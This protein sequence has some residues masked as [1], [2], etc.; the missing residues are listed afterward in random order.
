MKS[1]TALLLILLLTGPLVAAEVPHWS[2]TCVAWKMRTE[3]EKNHFLIGYLTG[4]ETVDMTRGKDNKM[5]YY[6]WPRGF[7][8]GGV[9]IEL[10][11]LCAKP[12]NIDRRLGELVAVF[13]MTWESR[14][15]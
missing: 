9:V 8:V 6:F 10:D 2:E 11:V 14:L 7:R 3:T 5:L 15:K 1:I 4:L 13:A 12:E